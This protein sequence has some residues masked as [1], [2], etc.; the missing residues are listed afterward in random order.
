[1]MLRT[2]DSAA[3]IRFG[4]DTRAQH[5]GTTLSLLFATLQGMPQKLQ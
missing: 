3:T 2:F 5:T 4:P 1:M